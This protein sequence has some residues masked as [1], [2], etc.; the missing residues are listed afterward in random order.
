MSELRHV[1]LIATPWIVACQAPLS[2][3]F[4]R[5][6]YQNGLLFPPPGDLPSSGIEPES[7]VSSALAGG[8]FTN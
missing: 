4:S 3:E 7:V 6:E 8:F 1:Q 2:M 5:Q